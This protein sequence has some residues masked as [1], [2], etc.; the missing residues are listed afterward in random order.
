MITINK[1]TPRIKSAYEKAGKLTYNVT[2][3]TEIEA[4]KPQVPVS[5]VIKENDGTYRQATLSQ[6]AIDMCN[7][8]AK[9]I[10]G[11]FIVVTPVGIVKSASEHIKLTRE[12]ERTLP[13]K[14]QNAVSEAKVKSTENDT[15]LWDNAVSVSKKFGRII[16]TADTPAGIFFNT[17]KNNKNTLMND[18]SIDS[19]KYDMLVN[20]ALKIANEE[21]SLGRGT[22]YRAYEKIESSDFGRDAISAVRKI[23]EG[24]G[25]ISLGMTRMK[26]DNF[27]A[28]EKVLLDKYGITYGDNKS[29]IDKPEK[30][31]IATLIHLAY[32]DK[33]YPVYL[34]RIRAVKPDTNDA[35]VQNSIKNAQIHI[36]DI[37]T[38]KDELT[39]KKDLV[40]SALTSIN[41]S[42]QE[43]YLLKEAGI[44]SQDL[45]DI[46]VYASTVELSEPAYL[47][48]RWNG[49]RVIPHGN[50]KDIAVKNLVN[51]ITQK[52]YV[53]NINPNSKIY[54]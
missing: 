36:F 14:I 45:D 18:L 20:T 13:L 47:A 31:A 48:A 43:K 1:I 46:R 22:K 10:A 2:H 27:S 50:E 5:L 19:E 32:L 16:K 15:L 42:K 25:T 29:N 52:G 7:K 17:L 30:S 9:F 33:D 37:F 35:V 54:Y 53:A 41:D 49:K 40:L 28:E 11:F 26:I 6:D 12:F 3:F 51:I 38:A 39:S 4:Q 23:K 24:D 21:S 8:F 44:T 34:D